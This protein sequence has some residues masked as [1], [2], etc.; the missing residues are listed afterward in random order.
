VSEQRVDRPGEDVPVTRRSLLMRLNAQG[1]IREEDLSAFYGQYKEPIA[2][3]ALRIVGQSGAADLAQETWFTIL[4]VFHDKR[5][6]WDPAHGRFHIWL[7]TI[8]RYKGIE[9]FRKSKADRTESFDPGDDESGGSPANT[10]AADQPHPSEIVENAWRRSLAD[11]AWG[12][13]AIEFPER[14]L[15]IFRALEAGEKPE[16]VAVR[17]ELSRGNVDLIKHQILKRYKAIV[18]QME[19]GQGFA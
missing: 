17:F 5:L 1:S 2:R 15:T 14:K 16:A 9:A 12:R 18:A 4:K 13:L 3:W 19:E 7:K 11:V 10:L 8:L 6:T